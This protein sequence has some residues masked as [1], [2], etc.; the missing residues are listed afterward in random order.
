[1]SILYVLDS[2]ALIYRSYFAF[3]SRPLTNSR[4]QNVSAVHG[5]FRFL[6]SALD[7][8]KPGYIAA[9]FDSRTPTF[10][11]QMYGGYKATRQ[12][13]PEDL[14]AQVPVIEDILQALGVPALSCEGFE[15]DDVIAAVSRLCVQAG[16]GCRILSGDKDLMQLLGPQVDM[17]RSDKT[18]GWEVVD[19]GSVLA[20]WGVTP[21]QM[22]DL[23]S[24]S[25]DSAD[26]I[27]GV[28]GVGDKTAAK[29]LGTYGSLDNIYAH[30]DEIP[31]AMGKKIREGRESAYFS[32]SLIA[33]RED[34][35]FLIDG[36]PLS[37]PEALFAACS[38]ER[39]RY[40]EAAGALSRAELPSIAK[41]YGAGEEAVRAR[42]APA[43]GPSPAAAAPAEQA[44]EGAVRR[45][46]ADYRAVRTAAELRAFIDNIVNGGKKA[47]FDLETDSLNTLE[48]RL[49]GFSLCA[50]KGRGVYVPLITGDALL[51]EDLLSEAE[52]LKELKRLFGD[53]DCLLVMHNGKFDWEVLRSHGME[54]P[55]A[56]LFDTMIAAWLLEADRASFSLESLARAKLGLEGVAFKDV[57]PKGGVFTDVGVDRAVD[58]AAEDAD[59]TW[60]LY[61]Y[62]EPRLREANLDGLFWNLEMPLVPVLADMEI[63]GIRLDKGAL[64]TCGQEFEGRIKNA[65]AEI[66]EIVG[67]PFNIASPLQLQEVLFTERNLPR[68][69]KTKTGFSTDTT[70]L[71]ELAA[72]DPVPKK[73]LEYRSM[74]K[75]KSTYVD[76]LIPLADKDS[77]VHTSFI[78]TGTATGRLSSRDPNLQNIPVREEDGR[79]IR[80]AFIAGEG[81]ALVSADYSQIELVILAHLSLDENLLRAFRSG[82]DVHRATAAL[83]FG[84]DEGAVTPDMRRAAKAVNFGVM[85]GMSA[86][87]LSNEL[88]ISRSQAADFLAAYNATYSGVQAYFAGVIEK[89]EETGYVETLFGR[90]RAI[91]EIRS[92]N[93]VEKAAAERIAKNTPIQGSAADVVKK[94]MLALDGAL[95][96]RAKTLDA[97]LLLQ[98]HDELILECP[99]R[100]SSEVQAL[101]K[102]VME[103]VVTLKAPLRVSVEAG[104]CWGD[105]H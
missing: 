86:F 68:G 41:L 26:N 105:F 35:P 4:G 82:G 67:H 38:T 80:R 85:Y 24:L 64:L 31:G 78:Q 8:Y 42:A 14:H 69:K 76:A 22:L 90:R 13:A 100:D 53:R 63:A 1:M 6:K 75:L 89:A 61:E 28:P 54:P 19:E 60:Q 15:A 104:P 3:I 37:G 58:Y 11:H 7:R 66:F 39:L 73:I 98:V 92:R 71:E 72:L 34:A 27:P 91:P 2:Y 79:K 48:A 84:V 88:G 50:E 65:E 94:A 16:M 52:A 51:E 55:K 70:V 87:R 5:F 43:E 83:I 25:G 46:T 101:V 102:E 49:A 59:F 81:R 17:L 32:K 99:A 9:A 77:R 103:G 29:L 62:Y 30:A 74:A 96:A 36:K 56:K 12:K 40:D 18:G 97:R 21:A 95:R 57:V 23:L 44:T 10:R 45:N 33:L 20:E 47:A 93:R